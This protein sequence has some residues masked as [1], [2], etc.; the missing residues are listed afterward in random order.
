MYELVISVLLLAA[1]MLYRPSLPSGVG[2]IKRIL[3]LYALAFIA[4]VF[5]PLFMVPAFAQEVVIPYGDMVT[6]VLTYLRDILVVVIMGLLAMLPAP[7]AA[8]LKTKQVEQLLER[9]IDY[10]IST[11]KGAVS[12]KSLKVNV[13]NQVLAMAVQYAVDEGPA[14]IIAFLGGEEAMK[15]KIWARLNLEADSGS[16]V[17]SPGS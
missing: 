17:A 6:Q 15:K 10:G 8:F 2:G 13:G 11:T 4:I 14:K 12:G 1:F 3:G 16:P 7:I 9:A 5:A